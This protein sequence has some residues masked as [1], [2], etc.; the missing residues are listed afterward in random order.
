MCIRDS[1]IGISMNR[2]IEFASGDYICIWNVDD[3]RTPDSIE[4]MAKTLDDNP[5]IDVLKVVKIS[6]CPIDA[7]VDVKKVCNYIS[8]KKGGEGCVRD[9]IEQVM[10]VHNKWI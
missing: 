10:R 6:A 3:L 1:P 5:D 7:S 8:D 9:V 2:C 4:V